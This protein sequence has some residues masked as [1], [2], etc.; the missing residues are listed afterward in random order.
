[1]KH[2][3]GFGSGKI[4]EYPDGTAAYVKTMEFTQAFR[5]RIAD[6]T[7]FSV[8]NPGRLL[9][10]RL[11]VLGNGSTLAY[12]DVPHGVAE[13]IEEW[14]RNH[15]LFHGNVAREAPTPMQQPRS[16]AALSS[17]LIADELRKLADLRDDGILTEDEFQY[18]KAKLLA[19]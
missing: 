12:V 9:E 7:G 16:G 1:M 8:T 6:V 5:V 18:Q 19:Q 4:L 10:R 17:V 15:E 11:H 13:V 14:F 2:A 3:L